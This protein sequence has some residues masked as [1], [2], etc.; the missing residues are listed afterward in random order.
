MLDF[1]QTALIGSGLVAIVAAAI[2]YFLVLRGQSFAGHAL[3]H[4]GFAGATG[5]VLV[6][7][8]PFWGLLGFT[9]IAG[10]IM[11]YLSEELE[12]H[13]IA[14]GMILSAS[15]GLGLLFLHF[16]TS[17]ASQVTALLFGNVLGIAPE[18]LPVL[19]GL[20][21]LALGA[22]ALLARPLIF[23]SLQPELAEARGVSLRLVSVLFL[24][25]AGLAIA[26]SAQVVGML[27]VFTLL[28]GPPAAA[29]NLTRHVS[30]GVVLSIVLGLLAAWGGIGL[31]ILTDWPTSFCI[32]ALS[33]A[34]YSMSLLKA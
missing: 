15:L 25:L 16:Y 5:A 18:F 21:V 7:L 14:V 3:S 20:A 26:L 22:L 10:L 28:I 12:G 30:T 27:L 23:S 6:G 8:P 17:F 34:I 9:G 1:L 4:I 24:G 29:Q 11:G 32:T 19:A 2:G 33:A 13:D 31:A